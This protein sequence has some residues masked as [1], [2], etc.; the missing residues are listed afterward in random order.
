MITINDYVI[1]AALTEEHTLDSEVTSFPVE[2]GIDITDHVRRLPRTV[3]IEGIVS[4]SPLGLAA[5]AR[6]VIIDDN[7]LPSD[8]PPS[9]EAFAYLRQIYEAAQPVTITTS[10]GLY[11][12]MVMESLSIPRSAATGGA[13]RFNATFREVRIVDVRR[14]RVR[15]SVPRASGTRRR[16]SSGVDPYAG[17]PTYWCVDDKAVFVKPQH[18]GAARST[19]SS[20]R[21]DVWT[22]YRLTPDGEYTE[23]VTI[24]ARK[25]RVLFVPTADGGKYVLE[26]RNGLLSQDEVDAM[27]KDLESHAEITD[28]ADPVDAKS[29]RA[30]K[31]VDRPYRSNLPASAPVEPITAPPY[32]APIEPWWQGPDEQP[33]APVNLQIPRRQTVDWPT[34]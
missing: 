24:C 33:P 19:G 25:E 1:D 30:V 22:D 2:R 7:A 34:D 32:E 13:L 16:G 18:V 9:I 23:V 21:G 28:I 12:N 11:E 4:D 26:G 20:R 14:S 29:G 8:V 10:L 5:I 15:V 31:F 17:T 27:N 3:S 6:Q